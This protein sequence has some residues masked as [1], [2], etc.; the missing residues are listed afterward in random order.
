MCYCGSVMIEDA[1]KRGIALLNSLTIRLVSHQL[2]AEVKY[3]L[4]LLI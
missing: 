2:S 1:G 3:Q 4:T